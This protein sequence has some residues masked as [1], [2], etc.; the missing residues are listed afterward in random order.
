V[1]ILPRD[2]FQSLFFYFLFSIFLSTLLF[3]IVTQHFLYFDDEYSYVICHVSHKDGSCHVTCDM[4]ESCRV[5]HGF[6][7]SVWLHVYLDESM[8]SVMLCK[9]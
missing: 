3:S 1:R 9:S 7:S 5:S 4:D 2:F 6:S 8:P